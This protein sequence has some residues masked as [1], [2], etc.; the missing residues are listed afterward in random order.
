MSGLEEYK[1]REKTKKL[2]AEYKRDHEQ[3]QI[4]LQAMKRR[5]RVTLHFID[6]LTGDLDRN[7]RKIDKRV[8]T[9]TASGVEGK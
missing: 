1:I 5:N 6:D 3:R 9:M 7:V 2:E 8:K 4:E